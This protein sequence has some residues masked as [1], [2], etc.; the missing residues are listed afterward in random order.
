M[1]LKVDP[2]KSPTFNYFI[3]RIN[4]NNGD[5]T[6]NKLDAYKKAMDYTRK[7]YPDALAGNSYW[8]QAKNVP[9]TDLYFLRCLTFRSY[10]PPYTD[11]G[12]EAFR[13]QVDA[14]VQKEAAF[15][16][17]LE[18]SSSALGLN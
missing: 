9:L 11:D 15:E 3:I 10:V 5:T 13:K 2:S 16:T 12:L 18:P 17:E 14:V 1:K 4:N 8:L 6:A 7:Q